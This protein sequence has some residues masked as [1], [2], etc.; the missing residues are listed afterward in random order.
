MPAVRL[1]RQGDIAEVIL[2]RPEKHNA[3][4]KDT[5]VELIAIGRSLRKDRDLRAVILRAEGPSFC[6]G[7]DIPSFMKQPRS[8][9]RHFLRPLWRST[10]DFQEVAWVWRELPVPVIAVLHGRCYGAGLQIALAADFRL[11]TPDCELSIMEAKWGLVPDMSGTVTLREVLPLDVAK[12]LAMTAEV[13]DAERGRELGLI[14]ETMADP[15]AAAR[16]LAATLATRSPDSVASTKLLFQRAW[17]ASV[18]KAFRLERW[19][20]FRLLA[21]KN[22]RQA[23]KAV[24][25]KE[26]ARFL[27]RSVQR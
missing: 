19:Y 3:V 21:G 27:P 2:D 25:G 14:T 15:L 17:P 18:A 8:I 10:N 13:F 11:A 26:P 9:L 5:L 6:S 22:Q 12:K 20:Q 23:V 24:Q 1:Q 7:L 16:A 4:G